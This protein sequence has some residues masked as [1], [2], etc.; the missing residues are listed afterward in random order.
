MTLKGSNPA[1]ARGI[2]K[3]SIDLSTYSAYGEHVFIST[4]TIDTR[5]RFAQGNRNEE[6]S[7]TKLGSR[8][9]DTN[10]GR[11]TQLGPVFGDLNDPV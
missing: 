9:Y 8:Y 6:T 4:E 11:F 3:F 2:L 10:L 7:L 1:S 5:G